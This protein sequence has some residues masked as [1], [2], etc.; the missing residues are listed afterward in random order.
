MQDLTEIAKKKIEE[1][2]QALKEGKQVYLGRTKIET[3][4]IVPSL[5]GR[6]YVVIIN[7]RRIMYLSNFVRHEVRIV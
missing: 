1:I 2:Q 7:K 4:E 3:I 6:S 5:T